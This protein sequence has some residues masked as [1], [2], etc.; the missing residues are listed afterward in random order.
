MCQNKRESGR[1]MMSRSK[2]KMVMVNVRTARLRN[3]HGSH[4]IASYNVNNFPFYNEEI[5]V[6]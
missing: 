1:M 6:Y 5:L 4:L 3:S 2:M